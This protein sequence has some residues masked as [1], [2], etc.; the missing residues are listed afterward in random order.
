MLDLVAHR[1]DR[2][3]QNF[4]LFHDL[5]SYAD[6]ICS[7][8]L[9][10]SPEERERELD[11]RN[12]AARVLGFHSQY[13][14]GLHGAAANAIVLKRPACD[15]KNDSCGSGTDLCRLARRHRPRIL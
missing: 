14:Q 15:L 1:V 4:L 6:T 8:T 2:G 9:N 12:F 5:V 11:L 13:C 10:R 7:T 3:N